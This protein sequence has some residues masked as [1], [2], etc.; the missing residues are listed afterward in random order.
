MANYRLTFNFV[1]VMH[2]TN[3]QEIME[4]ESVYL[5]SPNTHP[6][7]ENVI[8]NYIMIEKKLFTLTNHIKEK[9]NY[10]FEML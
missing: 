1:F 10:L 5:P 7:T 9:I 6:S 4:I 3:L 8:F 2:T